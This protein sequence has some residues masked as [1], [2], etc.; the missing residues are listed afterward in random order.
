M[1]QK[2]KPFLRALPF[3]YLLLIGLFLFLHFSRYEG[4]SLVLENVSYKGK[5]TIPTGLS[6]ARISRLELTTNG[7]RM[8]FRGGRS[9]TM[10]TEDGIVRQLG[11]EKLDE[12]ENSVV[13]SFKYGIS[14]TVTSLP[15]KSSIDITVPQ[16]IP[17][18]TELRFSCGPMENYQISLDEK[19]RM[20]LSD[21]TSSF[22]LNSS[23]NIQYVKGE[24]LVSMIDRVSQTLTLEDKAPGL[25]RTVREWLADGGK[26]LP[27]R[28][29]SI[30]TFSD[31]A[32]EGWIKR[33]DKNSGDWK[34]PG[35]ASE[36]SEKALVQFLSETFRRGEASLLTGDLLRAAEKHNT[37]LSWYSSPFSGDIV[38]KSGPILRSGPEALLTREKALNLS[39]NPDQSPYREILELKAML[40]R[41]ATDETVSWIEENIYP[42]IVWLEE[43]LYIFHP[44]APESDTLFTL[45]AAELLEKAGRESETRELQSIASQL[46]VSILDRADENG[47]LPSRI[48]FSRERASQGEGGIAPE[49]VFA[50]YEGPEYAP[51]MIDLSRE[52]GEGNWLYS[53]AENNSVRITD[54]YLELNFDFPKGQIHHFVV[55]GVEP[56]DRL[57]LHNIRWKSDPRFQRYS[58]GWV[59]DSVSKT[60]Y[61]KIKHRKTRETVRV[62]FAPPAPVEP[63]SGEGESSSAGDGASTAATA[64]APAG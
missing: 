39:A 1:N 59:Y 43:G 46:R 64:A 9:I 3:V 50:L 23:G 56:F 49:E 19:N 57:F 28:N 33:F 17:S 27:N 4:M 13:L 10:K 12:D 16:T 15:N 11:L 44:D 24:L 45:E 58:D 37:D 36:F 25:G 63:V 34:M 38:N 52:L 22:Y 51:H 6:P 32:Y 55:K 61:M 35:G 30:R 54:Q 29:E 48:S 60:L 47:I 40:D 7:L 31:K 42:L 14:I 62:Q 18:I 21:G 20:I 2:T 5:M 41:K 26:E 8:L 53:A